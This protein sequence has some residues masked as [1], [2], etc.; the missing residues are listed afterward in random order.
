MTS[1]WDELWE[2]KPVPDPKPPPVAPINGSRLDKWA[3]TALAD[4]CAEVAGTAPGQRNDRLNKASFAIGTIVGAGVLDLTTATDSLEGAGQMSGLDTTEV[5]KTVGSGLRAG[6]KHPRRLPEQGLATAGGATQT[7]TVLTTPPTV[8]GPIPGFVQRPGTSAPDGEVGGKA[9]PEADDGHE[10]TFW[11][12][13]PILHHVYVYAK[14]RRVSPWAVLG[15]LLARVATRVPPRVVLPPIVGGAASLN[16]FIALVGGSGSGKGAA[17]AVAT[18]AVPV[19]DLVVIKTGSGEGIAHG[20]MRKAAG[21]GKPELYNQ[22]VL[23]DIP[24]IDTLTALGNRQGATLLPE[25]RSGWSGEQLGFA[26]AD[27]AKRLS[28]AAHSYRMCLVAGVQPGRAGPLLHDTDAG[29]P[30]RFL[31]LPATDADA[32]DNPPAEPEPVAWVP[33]SWGALIMSGKVTA[34][35]SRRTMI[36]V[37]DE[38]KDTI[39]TARLDRARGV[40]DALDGHAL[41]ARLKAAATFAFLDSRA[42]VSDEDWW[43]SGVLSARSDATRAGVAAVLDAAVK[44]SNRGRALAEADRTVIVGEHVADKAVTR[45]CQVLVRR[46]RRVGEP[47]PAG[48]LRK[49]LASID[50]GYFETAI[51]RLTDAGLVGVQPGEYGPEYRLLERSS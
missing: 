26:Y 23:F 6:M 20:F 37:C 35:E 11:G 2:D 10:D 40:G 13:R 39:V 24:E 3:I 50:R 48:K 17:A 4:E 21:G 43:L 8:L 34:D 25:L 5:A 31:W 9:A 14:A 15:V 32:P 51:D 46:L 19:G 41:L 18:E 30:Q 1:R 7:E 33:P 38:A 36:E 22:A 49:S 27:P 12:A 28:V 45:V 47:M 42:N 16:Q 44:A 29:T